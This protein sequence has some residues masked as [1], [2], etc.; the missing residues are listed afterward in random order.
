MM[1]DKTTLEHEIE[2]HEGSGIPL[3]AR[4]LIYLFILIICSLGLYTFKL[5]NDLTIKENE[6]VAV[7][8][9]Y[10]NEMRVLLKRMR[11][12][13]QVQCQASPDMNKTD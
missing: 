12:M 1:P 8:E 9:H 10:E 2:R 4:L 3:R 6:V 7:S 13:E 5:N 11:S